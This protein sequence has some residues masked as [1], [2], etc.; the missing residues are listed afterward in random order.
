MSEQIFPVWTKISV[1]KS[2]IVYGTHTNRIVYNEISLSK[3]V[4]YC[5]RP[6]F[7]AV[8]FSKTKMLVF[9]ILETRTNGLVHKVFA[10]IP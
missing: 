2:F 7:G 9:L 10:F 4:V 8:Y 3:S 6:N 5:V 1:N